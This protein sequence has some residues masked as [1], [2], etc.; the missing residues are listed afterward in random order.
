MQLVAGISVVIPVY[1]SETTLPEVV[2][3][4]LPLLPTFAQ[5][6]EVIL[7]NDGSRDKSWEIVQSFASAHS[8]IRG[9]NLARNYGQ[10]NATLAGIRAARQPVIVT[11]DADGQHPPGEI[12]KLLALIN[13]GH[14]VAYGYTQKPPYGPFRNLATI[15]TKWL[16]NRL[17]LFPDSTRVSAFRA[18][19]T[20]LRDVFA[21]CNTPYISVDALLRW[22][23]DR[24]STTLVQHNPRISGKSAISIWRFHALVL[25]AI[26]SYSLV[27]VQLI[28]IAGALLCLMGI[29]GIVFSLTGLGTAI[30]AM[31]ILTG[32]ILVAV[33][34]V[35][36]YIARHY[37]LSLCRSLVLVREETGDRQ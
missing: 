30:S 11:M 5:H 13:E 16:I 29:T 8:F 1:N 31:C 20:H 17:H 12:S 2:A 27:P 21:Q 7:V 22:S 10:Q 3:A 26:T 19:R 4:L 36:E 25:N 6:Y 14:D 34:I 9:I 23:T 28:E 37:L 24:F 35:G 32:I 33:G 15:T 18:L